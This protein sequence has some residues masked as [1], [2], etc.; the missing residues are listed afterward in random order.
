MNWTDPSRQWLTGETP[1]S[2]F[3]A[4]YPGQCVACGGRIREGDPIAMTDEGARHGDC[5]AA[6]PAPAREHPVCPVCWLTHPEG[7]CDR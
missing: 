7:A 6:E 2:R 5:D 4:R 3:L 1:P